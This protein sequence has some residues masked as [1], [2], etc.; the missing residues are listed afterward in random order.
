MPMSNDKSRQWILMLRETM[1]LGACVHVCVRV[2]MHVGGL[3]AVAALPQNGQ[4]HNKRPH[5]ETPAVLW[6][7]L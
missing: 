5:S 2:Y 7:C 4:S 6:Q 1:M 3:A